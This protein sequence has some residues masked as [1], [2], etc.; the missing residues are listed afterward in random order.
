MLTQLGTP[1]I[2]VIKLQARKV[3][4]IWQMEALR[5][6]PDHSIFRLTFAKLLIRIILWSCLI[7]EIRCWSELICGQNW[8]L[9][10]N[11][12][13]AMKYQY[14]IQPVKPPHP[15]SQPIIPRKIF[16][17]RNFWLPNYGS[18]RILKGLQIESRITSK[19][20]TVHQLNS[21]TVRKT[22]RFS[23]E[24]KHNKLVKG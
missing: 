17:C 19:L 24:R 1:R 23:Q 14:Q 4:S 15:D 11:R 16:S 6:F 5:K 9:H 12:R 22:K 2:W 3:R 21:V 20:R 8:V 13:P 7:S 18:L 10:W